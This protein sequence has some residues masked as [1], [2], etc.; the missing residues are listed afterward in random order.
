[1]EYAKDIILEIMYKREVGYTKLKSW[2]SK[3]TKVIK[4]NKVM[5]F[6]MTLLSILI[7][8]D[9]TLVNSFLNILSNAY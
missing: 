1:M 2:T 5:V 9:L 8:I 4:N 6:T 7:I 3:F